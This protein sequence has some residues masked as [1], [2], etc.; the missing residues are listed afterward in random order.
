MSIIF[1]IYLNINIRNLCELHNVLLLAIR[2]RMVTL[3]KTNTI[4]LINVSSNV[5]VV[6]SCDFSM[7][8]Y[9]LTK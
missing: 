1:F 6:H 4:Y 2:K 3:N 9:F 8:Y 5:A 7:F